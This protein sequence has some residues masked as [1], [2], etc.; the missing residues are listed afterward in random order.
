MALRNFAFQR[1]WWT[2]GM[3]RKSQCILQILFVIRVRTRPRHVRPPQVSVHLIP[4]YSFHVTSCP[5]VLTLC[6]TDGP[7]CLLHWYSQSYSPKLGRLFDRRCFRRIDEPVQSNHDEKN[8]FRSTPTKRLYSVEV[9]SIE[10]VISDRLPVNIVDPM[11]T[12][13]TDSQIN[14]HPAHKAN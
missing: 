11:Y 10:S 6:G 12:S 1:V 8:R 3:R 4:A 7:H 9:I 13:W 5:W 2:T 14:F